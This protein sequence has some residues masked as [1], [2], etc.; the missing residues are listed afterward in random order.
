ML[1]SC[2]QD[3]LAPVFIMRGKTN[4]RFIE[5]RFLSV[6]PCPC[7][8]IED[9]LCEAGRHR[10]ERWSDYT[11]RGKQAAAQTSTRRGAIGYHSPVSTAPVSRPEEG[12]YR[13]DKGW[14]R[15][16]ERKETGGKDVYMYMNGG[17]VKECPGATGPNRYKEL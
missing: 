11:A 12:K 3:R 5:G 6:L 7:G 17:R 9:D 10:R 15:G 16:R 1:F 14:R 8:A 2:I 13:T 4:T